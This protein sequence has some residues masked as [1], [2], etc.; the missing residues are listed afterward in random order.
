[1][2]DAIMVV[3]QCRLIPGR[4]MICSYDA[5][6]MIIKVDLAGKQFV[7]ESDITDFCENNEY[8]YVRHAS[9]HGDQ[10]AFVSE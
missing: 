3:T 6:I 10:F 1:M 2:N 9:L 5:H 8:R 4:L 7:V